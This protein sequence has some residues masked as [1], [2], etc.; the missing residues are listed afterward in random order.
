MLKP[1]DRAVIEGGEESIGDVMIKEFLNI[2]VEELIYEDGFLDL[3]G[4]LEG[5]KINIW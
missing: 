2:R 1:R 4:L 5:V 3:R